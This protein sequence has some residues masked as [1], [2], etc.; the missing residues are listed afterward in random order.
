MI[1]IIIR[2]IK[3]IIRRILKNYLF[4]VTKKNPMILPVVMVV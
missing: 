1:V 2:L 3:T 4:K